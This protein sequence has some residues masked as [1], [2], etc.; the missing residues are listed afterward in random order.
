[1]TKAHLIKSSMQLE[2]FLH[3][4]N[5]SPF[6]FIMMGEHGVIHG[7]RIVF[8][9]YILIHGQRVPLSDD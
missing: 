7:I 2:P 9:R 5:F 6:F 8:G 3:F 1:M 4:Q